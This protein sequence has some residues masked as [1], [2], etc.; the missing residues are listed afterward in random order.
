MNLLANSGPCAGEA[1]YQAI[2]RQLGDRSHRGTVAM[3]TWAS[4]DD[5]LALERFHA[6]FTL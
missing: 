3:E 1:N 2:A 5:V 6:A 4:G